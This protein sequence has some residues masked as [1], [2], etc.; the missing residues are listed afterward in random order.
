MNDDRA[1]YLNR[2][3]PIL[4]SKFSLTG[5]YYIRPEYHVICIPI[6]S[7][8]IFDF[9]NDLGMPI[10]DKKN[11]LRI[12]DVMFNSSKAVKAAILRGLLDTDGC[13]YARKDENYR[14][15]EVKITSGSKLFLYDIK[16]VLQEFGLPAYV[17]WQEK[18]DA[19]DVVLRGN[20][21]IERWMAQIGTSHPLIKERY[22]EWIETGRLLPK[23]H[24]KVGS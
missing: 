1:Y 21:N 16:S 7:K 9:L 22:N 19:G 10:G 15:L 2:I 3:I 18:R 17:H 23:N 11:K 12:T 13:I 6:K 24:I 8:R 4:K 14:Y 20:N 5:Y